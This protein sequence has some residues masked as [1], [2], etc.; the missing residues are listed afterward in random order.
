[1]IGNLVGV[2][3]G[4]FEVIAEHLVVADLE[5][6]NAGSFDFVGLVAGD[7]LLAAAGQFALSIQLFAKLVANEPAF[8]RRQRAI[9]DQRR[10]KLAK[11]LTTLA[12]TGVSPSMQP[13]TVGVGTGVAR[14]VDLNFAFDLLTPESLLKHSVG[15]TVRV[16]KT[17]PKTGEEVHIP[18]KRTPFFKVGK[19]LKEMVD[20]SKGVSASDDD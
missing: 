17:N 20:A 4:H 8:A 18:A 19:E 12:L 15:R 7:P 11:G 3:L 9:V 14:L 6:G 16:I 13:A 5:V 10:I 1:M 2:G